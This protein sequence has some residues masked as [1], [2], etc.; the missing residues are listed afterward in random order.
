VVEKPSAIFQTVSRRYLLENWAS[1]VG[2]L[3]NSETLRAIRMPGHGSPG[4]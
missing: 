2:D 3:R 1:G 4:P